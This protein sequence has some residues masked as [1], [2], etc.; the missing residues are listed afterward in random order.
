M[1]L[2]PSCS[3]D[4][5][6]PPRKWARVLCSQYAGT[7]CEHEP[8]QRPS[9]EVLPDEC[10][11]EILRR[12]P[13]GRDR[14]SCASVSKHWLFLLAT[15]R[16]A[17]ILKVKIQAVNEAE[18]PKDEM[19][20]SS[21]SIDEDGYLVRCLEGKKAT[22][23]RLI[24]MAV[25]TCVRGGLA[26]LSVR[27]SNLTRGV[28]D[29]GLSYIARACPSLRA[30]SLWNISSIRDKG[31]SEVARECHSLE[32]LDICH[33]RSLSSGGLIDIAR[34]CPNLKAFTIESCSGIGNKGLEA[35]G[36]FC[37]RLQ[38]VSI[39]DCPLVGDRAVVSLIFS[40]SSVLAKLGLQGLNIT[41]FSLAV[42]G[43]YGRA[44]TSLTLNRLKNTTEKGFWVMGNVRGLQRLSSLT[45]VSCGLT[46]IGLEA[47]GIGCSNLRQLC[48]QRCCFISDT[49]LV[50]F[51]KAAGSLESLQ[52]E[53]LNQVSI[54]GVIGVLSLPS[55]ATRLKALALSK[56]MGVKDFLGEAPELSSCISLQSLSIRNCPGFGSASVALVGKLCPNLHHVDFVG[57]WGLTDVGLLPFLER[58][59]EGLIRVNLS[60]CLNITDGAVSALVRLHGGTLEMLN[61]D[62]CRKVTDASLEAIADYCL[63]INDLDL[64]KCAITDSGIS[65]LSSARQVNLQVLSLSSCTQVSNRSLPFLKLLGESLVGLNLQHCRSISSTSVGILT[66][67]LWRC[68]ILY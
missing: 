19:K 29:L 2:S 10:L 1:D 62:S 54:E 18:D 7:K 22:D 44:V 50:S 37:P 13:G 9:I 4:V 6:Y 24:A 30:L 26:K 60:N 68:D 35:V 5:F 47:L 16:K 66:E 3:L 12:I 11:L 61:L 21:F 36:R 32:K 28:T 43:H 57:L 20:D 65:V 15:M 33:C 53:E 17:E 58:C 25:G 59:R 27:G 49:G 67:S 31:L 52:L 39:K 55:C 23:V 40:A 41:D 48:L 34:N 42:I 51:V 56:C 14:S 8:Y 45:I 64:S 63:L 46:D 38:S